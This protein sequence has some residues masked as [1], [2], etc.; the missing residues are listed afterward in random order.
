MRCTPT[1]SVSRCL[2]NALRTKIN[3]FTLSL[4]VT[5]LLLNPPDMALFRNFYPAQQ[6]ACTSTKSKIAS[7]VGRVSV[8]RVACF[9]GRREHQQYQNINSYLGPNLTSVLHRSRSIGT[10]RLYLTFTSP[11]TTA[12][13]LHTCISQAKRYAA[14][15]NSCHG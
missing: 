2:P 11:S 9:T 1:F 4:W 14:Q 7:F 10:A 13:E 15:P 8:S 6:L 3:A 12:S 5:P